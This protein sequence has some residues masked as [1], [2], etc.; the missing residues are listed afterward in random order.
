MSII[1]DKDK[2]LAFSQMDT[3]SNSP[4]WLKQAVFYQI[5]PQS[6]YD[7]NGDGIGD[8]PGIIQQLDYLQWLGINVVWINP[9]FVSPFRDAGYDVDDY[10]RIAPRYGTNRDLFRLCR[11]AHRRAINVC[12]DLVR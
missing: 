3:K 9:C 4:A 1:T 7:S 10:Y 6:V 2:L 11:E 12:L 8:I 5:Y